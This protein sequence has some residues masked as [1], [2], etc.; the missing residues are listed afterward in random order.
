VVQALLLVKN[1]WPPDVAFGM[2]DLH[3]QAFCIALQN[4]ER[5]PDKQ[6]DWTTMRW[7]DL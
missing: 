7:P 3:R 2:D 6:F 1:G 5:A 4:L